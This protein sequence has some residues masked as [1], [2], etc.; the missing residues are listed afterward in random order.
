MIKA[1]WAYTVR[2]VA[3]VGIMKIYQ[4]ILTVGLILISFSLE[5][6]PEL[7]VVFGVSAGYVRDLGL[8]NVDIIHSGIPS[9]SNYYWNDVEDDSGWISGFFDRSSIK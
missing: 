2:Q 4:K 8:Y 3:L 6:K 9:L 1:T 5:A 7:N